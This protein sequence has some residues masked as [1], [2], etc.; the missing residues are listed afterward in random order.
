MTLL[1]FMWQMAFCLVLRAKLE[2]IM[3]IDCIHTYIGEIK[4]KIDLAIPVANNRS[5]WTITDRSHTQTLLDITD[6]IAS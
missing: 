4:S 6:I 1:I 2:A 3:N 5:W